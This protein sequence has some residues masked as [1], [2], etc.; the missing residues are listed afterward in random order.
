MTMSRRPGIA[1]F[2]SRSRMGSD[3]LF[4]SLPARVRRFNSRSRMGS[5]PREVA[6]LQRRCVSIHAP[7]WGAT[8]LG[9]AQGVIDQF[10]FT[11]PHG[12][13]RDRPGGRAG[14]PGFNSRSRMG[15]DR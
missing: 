11:L 10:Q 2:N 6:A 7:A 8:D 3:R 9:R 13:R 4:G 1:R 5:D 12:E 15:S 14:W